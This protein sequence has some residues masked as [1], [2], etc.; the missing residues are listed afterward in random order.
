M[1]KRPSNTSKARLVQTRLYDTGDES[2]SQLKKKV[3]KILKF[4]FIYI[5]IGTSKKFNLTY[6]TYI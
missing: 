3:N 1:S 5:S 6:L 4:I 2:T